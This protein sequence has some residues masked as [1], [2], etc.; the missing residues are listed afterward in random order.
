MHL[1]RKRFIPIGYL[2]LSI[3]VLVACENPLTWISQTPNQ[4]VSDDPFDQMAYEKNK[5]LRL[6]KQELTGYAKDLSIQID[7]PMYKEFAANSTVL[8]SGKIG[9]HKQLSQRHLWIKVEK[10]TDLIEDM[11]MQFNYYLPIN[12]AD[13][14]KK[15]HLFAGIGEYQLTLLVSGENKEEYYPLSTTHV[16]NVNPAIK[17][18]ISYSFEAIEN[19]LKLHTPHAGIEE[20]E[21]VFQLNGVTNTDELLI[22]TRKGN[23]KWQQV[24]RVK[25]KTFRVDIPLLFGEGKHDIKV[26]LP[27]SSKKNYYLDGASFIVDNRSTAVRNPIRFTALYQ[28][29]GVHLTK[30]IAG[31]ELASDNLPFEGTIDPDGKKARETEYMIVQT[32][33]GKDKATYFI[34]V[35]DFAF[36]GEIPFRFGAGQYDVL[37]F[38]PEITDENRDFFRFF[39][40][41]SFQIESKKQ[42]DLRDLLP[43][44]GIPSDNEKIIA[45]GKKITP[46]KTTD[47][48]KAK[49]IYQYVA[50]NMKY[51]MK[52]LRHN[53]FAWDDGALKSLE[54]QSGVCQD[55]VFLA[56]ALLRA[57]GIPARFVEGEAGN[58]QHAW[59]EA[60]IDNRWLTMD[61]T[62]GSGYITHHGTFVRRY[63]AKYFDPPATQFKQT[64]KRNGL[65]Y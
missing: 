19:G 3:I 30:P 13:F 4:T 1:H 48:D 56:I 24:L 9:K 51:D 65:M 64:H 54:R 42:E 33:K 52:K 12:S 46:D 8:V 15:I 43:S 58:Q 16:I 59:I 61:P 50:Q 2:L 34:P 23:Q 38:V 45:L 20:Q 31:G 7:S 6:E 29:R 5:E 57:E 22:E 37:L 11:P 47:Y 40:V 14:S 63:D 17:R 53:T 35:R 25:N 55:F 32:V 39:T 49:A 28:Q 60:R 10:K 44:R 27:D 18:D 41:A 36:T 21:G 26:M 62:W